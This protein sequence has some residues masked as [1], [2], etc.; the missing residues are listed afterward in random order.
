MGPLLICE[1]HKA[2]PTYSL[3]RFVRL[4]ACHLASSLVGSPLAR[5]AFAQNKQLTIKQS[6]YLIT[7]ENELRE[8]ER[9][10]NSFLKE[11]SIRLHII[12]LAERGQ[13]SCPNTIMWNLCSA[14]V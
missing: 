5:P 7:L 13:I 10:P 9:V 2:F 12:A 11:V 6:S 8:R 3:E 14:I 1:G 4:C